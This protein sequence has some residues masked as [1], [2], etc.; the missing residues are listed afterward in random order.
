M[1]KNKQL[2]RVL[3]IIFILFNF[4]SIN[5]QMPD[6]VY[7]T[8]MMRGYGRAV[9]IE[10]KTVRIHDV[11]KI[12]CIKNAEYPLSIFSEGISLSDNVLTIKR[13]LT[14]YTLDRIAALPNLCNEKLS[15]K[16]LKSPLYNFD[17]LWNTFNEQYAYFKERNVD[18]Q[19]LYEIY[20]NKLNENTG[21]AE[22]FAIFDAML[23]EF[24]DGHVDISAS[25][26]I[27]KE[28]AVIGNWDTRSNPDL[29]SVRE[30]TITKYL[31][32]PKRHNLSRTVW[33]TLNDSIGY[34]QINS[35]GIQGSYGITD[36]TPPE[37]AKKIYLKY[38]SRAEDSYTDE[39]NGMNSTMKKVLKDL[40][41]T[42]KIILD[43]RFNGG[44]EDMVGLTALSYFIDTEKTVFHK[45]SRVRD[46]FSEAYPFE[47]SPA[48]TTYKG[49]LYLLQ[50][51]YSAS[52]TEILLLA[53]LSYDNMVRL[54]SPSEGI[55]SDILDK[56]LPNGWEFGLSNEIY[57][58]TN[59]ISYEAKGIPVDVDFN[60]PKDYYEL[61][62]RLNKDLQ[63]D[64][65]LAIEYILKN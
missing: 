53:S 12:S 13:G 51:H 16:E 24:N 41:H 65:D 10:D 62:A 7:G 59:G 49:K 21:K 39:L 58:D 48:E 3:F 45:K 61:V 47:L 60:Y 52:A 64:G 32:D 9:E 14:E 18:W 43:L 56:K 15:K 25:D 4:T 54:G 55:F 46:T 27:M 11:T 63:T 5:A 37:E 57:E 26:K 23:E 31:K 35:M 20:R 6:D 8:W 30:A 44:G 17:L 29:R 33:G 2:L 42:K 40:S 22:S 36:T 50:S 1:F 34:V 19:K 38:L 28:A